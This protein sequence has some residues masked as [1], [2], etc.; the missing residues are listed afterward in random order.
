MTSSG[1]EE[2]R[3]DASVASRRDPGVAR[4]RRRRV[5]LVGGPGADPPRPLSAP[6]RRET[7][8][9]M[10][11]RA[12]VS[13]LALVCATSSAV[14]GPRPYAFTKGVDTLPTAGIELESWFGADNPRT[15][16]GPN[17]EWW[18]GP[19]AGITDELEAGLFAI[20]AQP[21]PVGD[22]SS[23]LVLDSLR[24]Q[25]SYLLAPKA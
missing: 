13:A 14:A 16:P 15:M 8:I 9:T 1:S 4:D 11:N 7:L 12:H 25:A 18:L 10:G 24:L 21:A 3:D 23:P 17:W 6:S 5:W 2:C 19:V 22:V 20:F